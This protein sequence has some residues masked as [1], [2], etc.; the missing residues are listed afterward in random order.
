MCVRACACDNIHSG[1]IYFLYVR[2]NELSACDHSGGGLPGLLSPPRCKRRGGVVSVS[3]VRL[4]AR[5]AKSH[6]A[7]RGTRQAKP[8]M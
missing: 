4:F 2:T 5:L 8:E 7:A 6:T 3:T 1:V